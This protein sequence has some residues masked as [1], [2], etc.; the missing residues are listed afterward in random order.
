MTANVYHGQYSQGDG[1]RDRFD[2]VAGWSNDR[3]SLT[4]SAEHAE[5]RACGRAIAASASTA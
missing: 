2:V 1:A 4:L 5:R 3:L